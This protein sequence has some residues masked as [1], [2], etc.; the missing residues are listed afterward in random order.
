MT[1]NNKTFCFWEKTFNVLKNKIGKLQIV[2]YG[3]T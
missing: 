3:Y 2:H 1:A